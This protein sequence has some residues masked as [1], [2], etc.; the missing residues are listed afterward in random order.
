MAPIMA[1]DES[2]VG[3]YKSEKT[4]AQ[5]DSRLGSLRRHRSR[6]LPSATGHQLGG[7]ST[8]AR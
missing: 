1:S 8:N 6:G 7:A 5:P 2:R 3:K 4:E